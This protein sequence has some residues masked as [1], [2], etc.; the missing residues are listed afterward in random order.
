M[1]SIVPEGEAL[2]PCFLSARIP[3]NLDFRGGNIG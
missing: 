3:S 1:L 2:L